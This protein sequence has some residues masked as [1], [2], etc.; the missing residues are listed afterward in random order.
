MAH[1]KSLGR[2]MTKSIEIMDELTKCLK[3]F[4]HAPLKEGLGSNN[5]PDDDLKDMTKLFNQAS[6]EAISL[7][8]K[9]NDLHSMVKSVKT[10]KNS[11]F[12]S[13]V[14]TRFLENC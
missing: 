1:K 12:A 11:R 4:A 9:I 5:V 7:R 8:N 14:V 2:N 6:E 3:E 13:R 10:K